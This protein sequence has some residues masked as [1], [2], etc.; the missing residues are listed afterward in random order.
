MALL[1]EHLC[2]VVKRTKVPVQKIL[3][4]RNAFPSKIATVG[5]VCIVFERFDGALERLSIAVKS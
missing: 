1:V 4:V 5:R 3:I 2:M